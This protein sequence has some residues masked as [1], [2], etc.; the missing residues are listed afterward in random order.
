MPHIIH[1]SWK[2]PELP[3]NFQAFSESW[4]R[5]HPEWRYIL[6]SDEEN[7]ELAK[8]HFPWF[9]ETYDSFD[10]PVMRA[11]TARYMYMYV[12]GGVYADLD[13]ECLRP[14]GP[15]VGS[16]GGAAMVALMGHDLS[17]EHNIPNAFMASPPRHRLWLDA[18][19][20]V[21]AAAPGRNRDDWVEEVTGPVVLKAVVAR[22]L[23]ADVSV[24]ATG[25]HPPGG[26]A[27][28]SSGHPPGPPG[29]AALLSHH[30]GSQ[31][32]RAL[33]RD[34]WTPVEPT[35]RKGGPEGAG[36]GGRVVVLPPGVIYPY[37]WH[38]GRP[39]FGSEATGETRLMHAL[40]SGWKNPEFDAARCQKLLVGP[41]TYA[42]T[43][44]TH[45]WGKESWLHDH[46]PVV[47]LAAVA[48]IL[49][50]IGALASRR[51]M[52]RALWGQWRALLIMVAVKLPSDDNCLPQVVVTSKRIKD[53]GC[54]H[55][56]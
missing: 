52:R 23:R 55:P 27:A 32:V 28:P 29:S 5:H 21:Q 36:P 48:N 13:M 45:S 19:R 50:V 9:L 8:R 22:Y 7:R 51:A 6:W 56:P 42:I 35:G 1:Q 25:H 39:E 41:N 49:A 17:F 20:A 44:W 11:D 18:L 15:V 43:Y 33:R 14:L 4:Q 38:L 26:A 34:A 2:T 37:D 54:L 12:Y 40:C 46:A 16:G 3:V 31:A 30:S 53:K 24:N 10:V 47:I